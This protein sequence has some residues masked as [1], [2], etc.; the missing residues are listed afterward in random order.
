[1]IDIFGACD[2]HIHTGPDVFE[3]IADDVET[4]Q[5]CKAAGMRAIVL[6]S[7]ADT[8]ML[9]ALHTQNQVEG[10]RIFGGVTLNHQ[11]GGINPAAADAALKLGAAIVWMPTYHSQ[12]HYQETGLLGAFGVMGDAKRSYPLTGISALDEDGKLVKGVYQVLELVKQ[13]DAIIATG[14]LFAQEALAV[15]EAAHEMGCKKIVMTHPFFAP[16]ECTVDQAVRAVELGAMLEFCAGNALNPIPK[17]ID[18]NLYPETVRR[19]GAKNIVISSDTGQPTK[20]IAPEMT[21][22]F[23][24]T[25]Y[26]LGVSE[27]D[28]RTM[29]CDNYDGLLDM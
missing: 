18:I 29:M 13:Y 6:K 4:A 3:R 27:R 10:I 9:R 7:H 5:F 11:A 19:V 23:A 26:H 1:M 14:H 8:T 21:R 17:P 15:I 20:T 16:P 24:Q 28:L 22:M 12:A 25:L 2:L